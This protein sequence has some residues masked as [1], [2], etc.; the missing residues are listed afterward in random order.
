MFGRQDKPDHVRADTRETGQDGRRRRT[1]TGPLTPI[2]T[3]LP[4]DAAATQ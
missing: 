2:P 1:L 4:Q 3:S